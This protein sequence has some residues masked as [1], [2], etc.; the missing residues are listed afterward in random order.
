MVF[1]VDDG[2]LLL[3]V[4]VVVSGVEG[5]EAGFAAARFA[6]AR[7]AWVTGM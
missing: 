2:V 5:P 3:L 4:V 6:A 1:G 7:A